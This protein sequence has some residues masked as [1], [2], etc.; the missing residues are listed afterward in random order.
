MLLDHD[1]YTA[2]T[3]T[4]LGVRTVAGWRL[5]LYGITPDGEPVHDALV[6]AA[7]AVAGVFLPGPAVSWDRHGVGMITIQDEGKV[8]GVF[9][10][11]WT[12]DGELVRQGFISLRALPAQLRPICD[13]GPLGY[14]WDLGAVLDHERTA[15]V[16][17]VFARP[18]GPDLDA[19][20][21]DVLDDVS[22]QDS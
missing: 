1:N 19:Y 13:D 5:K 20:L 7:L 3:V 15:F 10:D 2:R 14:V 9:L 21:A 18:D 12:R 11:Y 22:R 6:P 8:A 16:R 17:H 4:S